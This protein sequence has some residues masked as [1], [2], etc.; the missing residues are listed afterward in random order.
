MNFTALL[1]SGF[2]LALVIL[3][4]GLIIF[5]HELG[6]FL[7]AR[8]AGVRVLAFAMGFGP[9]LLSYRKGLGWRRGSSEPEY[10]HA[11][12][13]DVP[14]LPV[15]PT[16]YRLNILPFGGYVKMLGQEDANPN[17]V[18]HARDSY[19]SVPVWK[20]MVI[21]SAGVVMNVILAAFLFV[22]VFMVGLKTEP[23]KVG[24][25]IPGR[26]ASLAV[27]DNAAQAGITEPGLKPGD[28]IL[29]VNG[30]RPRSFNDLM[31][32]TAMG[33][34][35]RDVRLEVR[36]PG[37]EP[38]LRFAI[39][40][41]RS[42][43]S[44]LMEIGVLPARS[45]RVVGGV[46][47]FTPAE[48]EQ[49][50][51]ALA[52]VGLEGVEPGM[53]L[54]SAAGRP[55]AAA[56]DFTAAV[57]ASG[58]SP[59]PLVFT[60]EAGATAH[61][62]IAP[63]AELQTDLVTTAG[64]VAAVSH[65]LG[66]TPVMTVADAGRAEAQG[67]KTDDLFV[68]LGSADFPSIHAGISEIRAR[69]GRTIAA[70][71]RRQEPQGPR[72]IPLELRV[73]ADGT[74]G[75]LAG[76]T[77][78]DSTLLSNPPESLTEARAGAEPRPNPAATLNLRPGSRILSVN[79]TPI[80][81]FRELRG[82]LSTPGPATLTIE[83]PLRSP[84]SE[85]VIESIQWNIP[86]DEHAR[87]ARLSW[88]SPVSPEAL[89]EPEQFLLKADGP[90][91]ALAT[92]LHETRRVMVMTYLTFARLFDGTVKVEHLK[93]PVGIAHVGT[94]LADRGFI[95]LLFFMALI[96]VNLAVINFLPLPIVDGGQFLFLVAEAIRGRPLPIAIQNA[97]AIAGLALIGCV[98]IVV[99]FNDI[100]NLFRP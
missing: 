70:V 55:V 59:V 63:I 34:R 54:T 47:G 12:R 36:R 26:P 85:P 49:F 10:A 93:G 48:T 24:D 21:I 8:W 39:R 86:D 5:I 2:D 50:K 4:F 52:R 66:L 53:T 9:A 69:K 22:G 81:N 44:N 97:A 94:L 32:A 89:F 100:M 77:G 25:V 80:A 98:F 75:F 40:P 6:H 35:G 73:A 58:G 18:S 87:L 20:R 83:L 3:G 99:T 84:E 90:A 45:A 71:V 41:E 61:A 96:S 17:A 82:T 95:W 91:D 88:V 16:E 13:R 78:D 65:L 27:A 60:S 74:V 46:G 1:A 76:D 38:A 79:G 92:G 19:Q 23:A 62:A 67:L 30:E 43:L 37:V 42:R 15:S 68:R 51:A 56:A 29:L 14:D 57:R 64:S 72:D 11:I 31:V 7:A 28:E 33:A